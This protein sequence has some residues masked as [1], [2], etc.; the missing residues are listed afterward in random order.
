VCSVTN[1]PEVDHLGVSFIQLF[2]I[3]DKTLELCV[4]N[5]EFWGI[6]WPLVK[7]T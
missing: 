3:L 2:V 1:C 4:T 7:L 5:V 6:T